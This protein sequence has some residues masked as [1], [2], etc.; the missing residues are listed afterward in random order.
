MLQDIFP[1]LLGEEKPV[2]DT[3]VWESSRICVAD[4]ADQ[5]QRMKRR[6]NYALCELLLGI[7]EVAIRGARAR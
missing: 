7:A 3:T 1:Q 4:C 2:V 5:P 6:L